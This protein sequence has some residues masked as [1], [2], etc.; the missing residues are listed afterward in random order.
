MLNVETLFETLGQVYVQS[1]YNTLFCTTDLA[2]SSQ[3]GG[4]KDIDIE[5]LHLLLTHLVHSKDL[6]G[7]SAEQKEVFLKALRKGKSIV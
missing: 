3:E 7:I 1:M 5:L 2:N 6:S 4:L